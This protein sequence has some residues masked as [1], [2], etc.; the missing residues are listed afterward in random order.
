MQSNVDSKGYQQTDKRVISP[1]AYN[2][3]E[4][5]ICR[6]SACQSTA[7]LLKQDEEWFV[8]SQVVLSG[9]IEGL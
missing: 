8:S 9:H 1:G 4:P 6:I 5:D 2:M 3:R 7:G